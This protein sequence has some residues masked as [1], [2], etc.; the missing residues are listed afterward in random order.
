MNGHIG[1]VIVIIVI[2]VAIGV[3]AFSRRR[4][5]TRET[6]DPAAYWPAPLHHRTVSAGDSD[7]EE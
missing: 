2:L 3:T 4:G 6:F 1:I 7:D 5:S